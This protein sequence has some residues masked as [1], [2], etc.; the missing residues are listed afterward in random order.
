MP[1]V[2]RA[3][4]ARK[5]KKKL[6]AMASGYFGGRKNRLK[7]ARWSVLKAMQYMFRDRRRRKRDFRRLW[8]T[9]INAAAR[10]NGMNYNTFIRGLKDAGVGL[11]RKILAELAVNDAATFAQL[12]K[13][14]G[15]KA[16]A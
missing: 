9:R 16:A 4:H 10:L 15:T 2:K 11:D 6:F 1:R 3:V 12:A 7:E 5:R 8:I 14:A 13:M